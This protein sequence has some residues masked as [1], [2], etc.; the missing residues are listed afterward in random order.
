MI[1]W[2]FISLSSIFSIL[3]PAFHVNNQEIIPSEIKITS[4][5]DGQAIRGVVSI[6]GNTDI[7]G[8]ALSELTYSYAQDSTDTWFLIDETNIPI[9]DNNIAIWDT[10]T[11]SDGNYNLR[12][13]VILENGE[14]IY[15]YVTNL[16]VRNYS[17]IETDTP[18]PSITIS[19]FTEI[20][21]LGTSDSATSTPKPEQTRTPLPTNPVILTRSD[22]SS[23]L[24]RGVAGTFAGFLV[25][26]LYL[27]LRKII[28]D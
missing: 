2:L 4:I 15:V 22:L 28:E 9:K 24:L 25:I 1:R 10:T 14:K 18:N 3:T 6:E 21:L 27:S 23:S 12:L 11:I 20:P 26:G 19:P 5:S 8:F 13:T 16:R 7:E 17:Q